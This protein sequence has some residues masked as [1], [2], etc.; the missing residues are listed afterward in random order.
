MR[1]DTKIPK[2]QVLIFANTR[3]LIQQIKGYGEV[4]AKYTNVKFMLG[5]SGFDYKGQQI[6]V[7]TFGFIKP[8]MA[9]R[10]PDKRIDTSSFLR[11]S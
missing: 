7:T 6:V 10:D 11:R 1:V 8:N 4:M 5:E 9:I 3:E 2:I